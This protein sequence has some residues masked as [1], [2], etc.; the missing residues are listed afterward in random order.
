MSCRLV[1][2]IASVMFIMYFHSTN[3]MDGWIMDG[4]CHAMTADNEIGSN[5][6]NPRDNFVGCNLQQAAGNSRLTVISWWNGPTYVSSAKLIGH[7]DECRQKRRDWGKSSLYWEIEEKLLWRAYRKSPTLFRTVPS[8]TPYGL[9]FPRIF[10]GL[11]LGWNLW[12]YLP[13]SQVHN[14]TPKLQALLSQ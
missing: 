6:R 2:L 8:P 11:L 5:L 12:I 4:Y 13:N 1:Y 10:K 3:K 9:P 7:L 14:P